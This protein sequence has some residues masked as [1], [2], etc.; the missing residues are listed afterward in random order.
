MDKV[1]C[2]TILIF[3]LYCI[4]ELTIELLLNHFNFV[5]VAVS[6][7]VFQHHA[8]VVPPLRKESN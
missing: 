4:A 5:V 7:D 6:V 3:E 2:V 1:V 8:V